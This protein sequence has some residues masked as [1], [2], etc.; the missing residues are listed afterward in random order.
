MDL[1][2]YHAIEGLHARRYCYDGGTVGLA[3]TT[4]K[5]TRLLYKTFISYRFESV[6][7]FQASFVR[8]T[9]G[10]YVS[11]HLSGSLHCAGTSHFFVSDMLSFVRTE[12][13]TDPDVL[14]TEIR[15]SY[16]QQID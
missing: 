5:R 14:K 6:C 10:R 7:G 16:D 2:G 1:L 9:L 4:T 3:R 13:E 12:N 15:E 11:S 8:F